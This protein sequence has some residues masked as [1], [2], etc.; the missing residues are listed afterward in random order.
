M[1]ATEYDYLDFPGNL[2]GARPPA[3]PRPSPPVSSWIVTRAV[4]VFPVKTGTL[5]GSR[6]ERGLTETVL[7]DFPPRSHHVTRS[8]FRGLTVVVIACASLPG[9]DGAAEPDQASADWA[10]VSRWQNDCVAAI[11]SAVA[12]ADKIEPNFQGRS[13]Y[14]QGLEEPGMPDW[15]GVFVSYSSGQGTQRRSV[16]ANV[17]LSSEPCCRETGWRLSGPH[18]VLQAEDEPPPA[19]LVMLSFLRRSKNGV[20]LSIYTHR[21]PWSTARPLMKL[22]KTTLDGCSDAMPRKL[23]QRIIER[24]GVR[25]TRK[26]PRPPR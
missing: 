17:Q 7:S 13:Q 24:G 2:H 26:Y 1:S 18:G 25:T 23:A 5:E 3:P 20:L 12:E 22:F 4:L 14:R 6:R 10:L 16:L 19:E 8:R 21:L 15:P 9:R 11:K